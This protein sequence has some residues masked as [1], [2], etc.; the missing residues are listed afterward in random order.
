M[1][2]GRDVRLCH[3]LCGPGRRSW[4]LDLMR[5]NLVAQRKSPDARGSPEPLPRS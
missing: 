4:K 5:D 2:V 3:G 1:G